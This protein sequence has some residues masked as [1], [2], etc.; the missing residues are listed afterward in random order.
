MAK[1][2]RW[3]PPSSVSACMIKIASDRHINGRLQ[4][5]TR[6]RHANNLAGHSFMI[7]PSDMS[8]V[9]FCDVD[10]DDIVDDEYFVNTQQTQ[11]KVI[12]DRWE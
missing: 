12:T 3:A 8:E 5:P 1:G 6:R 4:G 2:V 7:V 9:G 10:K 11:L